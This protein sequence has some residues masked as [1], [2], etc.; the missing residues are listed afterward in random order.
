MS[1]INTSGYERFDL[2]Q[3][4]II[5]DA[6]LAKSE[7]TLELQLRERKADTHRK[8]AWTSLA[9]MSTF[10]LL[11]FSPTTSIERI[12]ALSE[13]AALFYITTGGVVATFMGA[14]VWMTK[15]K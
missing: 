15:L 13:L 11:L 6:D 4:G 12:D 9:L 2:D 7:R 3:D 14:N 8:M 1:R 5:T 10:T